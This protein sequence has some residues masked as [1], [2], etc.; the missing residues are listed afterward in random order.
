MTKRLNL[1][2]G[3]CMQTAGPTLVEVLVSILILTMAVV[4]TVNGYIF[5][6]H[7]AEWSAHSLA[8]HSLAMQ[9]ME[10]V[11]AAKWD[12]V[13]YPAVD[14]VV[15][16]NFPVAVDLLDLPASGTNIAYATNF[17]TISLVS[18]NPPFKLVR[19]VC[20]WPFPGRG[21]FTN[22]VISYRSPDQ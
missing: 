13:A 2:Q 12:L 8:A 6:V 3:G 9:R 10:Q 19:V 7:R 17:T 14:Q 1:Q 4:A 11:R 21:L 20:V 15:Q 5:S 16:T 18:S 22:T